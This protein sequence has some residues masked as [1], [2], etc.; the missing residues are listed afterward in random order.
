MFQNMLCFQKA[1]KTIILLL[2]YYFLTGQSDLVQADPPYPFCANNTSNY[3]SIP[4]QNTLNN[5]FT[6]LVS[7]SF[8]SKFYNTSS[9]SSSSDDSD[10]VYGS[11]MCLRYIT[12]ENCMICVSS[13]TRNIRELCPSTTEAVVWEE[14]CQIRY[15]NKNFFGSL[16]VSENR[17]LHNPLN[18]SEPEQ[19][20]SAVKEL[21]SHLTEKAAFDPSPNKYYAADKK[22][23][24]DTDDT[25]H[26]VVQ[27]SGDLSPIDCKNCLEIAIK[28]ASTCCSFT[29]GARILSKS[30]Y[31]RYELYDF[32]TDESDT[33]APGQKWVP[34]NSSK[35]SIRMAIIFVVSA[36]LAMLVLGFFVYCLKVKLGSRKGKNHEVVMLH[37]MGDPNEMA[38]LQKHFQSRDEQKA[39]EFPY[40]DLASIHA[41]TDNFAESNLLGQGGFG[42][43]YKG[44][45]SDG[46]EVAVK[47]LSSCSE[48]GSEEFSNEV[49]LIMKLQHKN[50]VRLLGFCVN[51]AEN[52]LVYE[53][54]P[55]GSLDVLL[56]D[57]SKRAQLDWSSRLNIISGI[58]KGMLYLHE[59]SRLRIIHRD[60]K[61]SNVLLD[62]HMNPKISDFGMARIFVGAEGEASTC[63]LVGTYGYMAPEYAMEGHYSVKSDVFSFGVLLFEIITGKRSAGFQQSKRAPSLIA[64]AWQLWNEGTAIE[65]MDP[66]LT[67]S[68]SQEEFLRCVYLGLLCVQEDAQDRPTMSSVVVMLNSGSEALQ[69][70]ERPAFSWG[71]S[72]DYDEINVDSLSIN[73]IK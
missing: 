22:A 36:F 60:L 56:F 32:Y 38:I 33:K 26:A 37:N 3:S 73:S 5:L 52:L 1:C 4:S 62:S 21:L 7:K 63:R 54:M 43:V 70:P 53:Y 23:Y 67:D 42:P 35:W 61:A 46:R 6:S 66:L 15:S 68:C 18:I 51:G 14:M 64:Y 19:L 44:E 45:L 31:L 34:G 24:K 47:R 40:I 11:Y 65:L 49:L 57:P 72:K 41:A 2:L 29:H 16:D 55:N 8:E 10:K 30:C 71:I 28:N 27:C 9:S 20:G 50:L 25:L 59:D 39:G 12:N 58:A 48:Q 17:G 69:Q 13:A